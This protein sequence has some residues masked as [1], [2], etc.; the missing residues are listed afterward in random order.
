MPTPALRP[1]GGRRQY[2]AGLITLAFIPLPN[3]PVMSWAPWP[4]A[5]FFLAAFVRRSEPEKEAGSLLSLSLSHAARVLALPT[6]CG[7]LTAFG[8][9]VLGPIWPLDP[10]AIRPSA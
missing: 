6:C 9:W 7:L 4:L 1:L 8:V 5:S 3:R 2:E 10:P